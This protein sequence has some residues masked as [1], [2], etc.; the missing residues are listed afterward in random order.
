MYASASAHYWV[1]RLPKKGLGVF[2]FGA[3]SLTPVEHTASA[4]ESMFPLRVHGPVEFQLL[5]VWAQ[6]AS[7]VA[8]HVANVRRAVE[9]YESFIR[10]A[11]R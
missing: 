6:T 5:A 7:G 8:G 1:G 11:P 3:Y 9:N 4:P 10:E 2:T